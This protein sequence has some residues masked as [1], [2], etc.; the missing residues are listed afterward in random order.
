MS[1]W[2]HNALADVYEN[3]ETGIVIFAEDMP[4]ALEP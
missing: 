4:K 1:T 3:D 2:I